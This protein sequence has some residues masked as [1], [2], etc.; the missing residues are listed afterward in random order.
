MSVAVVCSLLVQLPLLMT[1]SG[2]PKTLGHLLKDP[3]TGRPLLSDWRQTSEHSRH[4]RFFDYTDGGDGSVP[5]SIINT[6]MNA[7]GLGSRSKMLCTNQR[8]RTSAAS[9][10]KQSSSS[11]I[12]SPEKEALSV[13]APV[14]PL[15]VVEICE[16]CGQYWSSIIGLNYCCRCNDKVLAFC[17]EAVQGGGSIY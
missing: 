6:C 15:I 1:A 12:R 2:P 10:Q 17:W 13:A 3:A 11:Y 7:N 4:R 9:R 16:A 14:V 8:N 5:K